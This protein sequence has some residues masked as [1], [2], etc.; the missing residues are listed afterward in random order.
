MKCNV[1]GSPNIEFYGTIK[2]FDPSFD[3]YRCR[4]CDSLM[5]DASNIEPEKFYGKDYYEGS[6]E[7]SYIDERKVLKYHNY[8]WDAR[9]RKIIKHSPPSGKFL[10]VGCSFG[11]FV[12][13]AMK[14]YSAYGLDISR[15]AIQSGNHRMKEK[16]KGEPLFYGSLDYLP[17]N[18]VFKKNTFSVI[19]M[20]EVAEHLANPK[21]HFQNAYHLLKD[22]G[23]LLIQTANFHGWQAINA[24]LDYHYFLPGHL[25]YYNASSLKQLLMKV[26]FSKFLEFIPV[27]FGVL[28]K[29]AK[30]RGSFKNI[31]DYFKW[32]SIV[33]YHYLSK[34][35]WKGIPLTSSYVLFA[36]K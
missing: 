20:I 24:G 34:I 26:G 16:S 18:E 11:G 28:A 35:K 32:V 2:R 27:E 21:M 19:T 30:S 7:Y 10:D 33:Q 3:I 8:V 14:Y 23:I 17:E 22:G 12:Q 4:D 1:C 5:Q 25:T 13:S 6:Q 31:K 36:F 29:L 9:L 15:Y